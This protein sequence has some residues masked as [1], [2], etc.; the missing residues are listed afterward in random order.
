MIIF[1]K[2]YICNAK[3]IVLYFKSEMEI[4]QVDRPVGSRFFD[5]P[6]KPV[7]TPVKLSFLETKRHLST[8]W[9][10]R[11]YY[12]I[13]K[14]FYKKKTALTNQTFR[15]HLL[16]GFKQWLKL[17]AVTIKKCTSRCVFRGGNVVPC[18]HLRATAQRKKV[19]NILYV[20]IA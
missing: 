1:T 14:T 6:V 12:I 15:K 3:L 9:N 19:K 13:N 7:E 5:R 20:K 2:F 11:I 4:G 16:N 18:A 10:A 8:N 17:Y